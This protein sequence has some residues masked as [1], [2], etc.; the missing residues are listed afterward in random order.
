MISEKPFGTRG[1]LI[2]LPSVHRC[3][4]RYPRHRGDMFVTELAFGQVLGYDV[5]IPFSSFVAVLSSEAAVHAIAAGSSGD[6][7]DEW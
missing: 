6:F 7:F 2:L 3:L 5:P 1:S 4:L